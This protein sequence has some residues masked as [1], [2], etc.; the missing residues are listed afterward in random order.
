MYL[1]SVPQYF[2]HLYLFMSNFEIAANS[3]TNQTFSNVS[4]TTTVQ[5]V[6]DGRP[7]S[8]IQVA[9]IVGICISAISLSY[10][11][12]DYYMFYVQT[13]LKMLKFISNLIQFVIRFSLYVFLFRVWQWPILAIAIFQL[14]VDFINVF[15][16]ITHRS[17]VQL[18]KITMF[19][20][21]NVI[22]LFSD[23]LCCKIED[24]DKTR[25]LAMA[26]WVL[27]LLENLLLSLLFFFFFKEFGQTI[28]I[29]LT[30][31]FIVGLFI[32][33]F[34]DVFLLFVYSKRNSKKNDDE[35]QT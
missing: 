20:F 25:K 3:T 31:L 18:I 11:T 32:P 6:I 30:V 26:I 1:E 12:T 15:K 22:T 19:S 2:L 5:M 28:R 14:V 23:C 34:I 9:Q 13:P 27:Y 35:I 21:L 29:V 10:G 33:F 17:A 4:A 7:L 8:P 24:K 16:F